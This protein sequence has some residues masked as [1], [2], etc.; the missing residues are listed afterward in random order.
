LT[1][2]PSLAYYRGQI[3]P[4]SPVS[5]HNAANIRNPKEGTTLKRLATVTIVVLACAILIA[6][7]SP[8]P[9]PKPGPEV[10]KL[11]YFAGNWKVEGETKPGPMGPG[12]KFTGTEHNEWMPGGFFLLSHGSETGSMGNGTSMAVYGYDLNEK[13]YTFHEFSSSGE[14]VHAKATVSGDTWTWTNEDKMEG[15][16]VRGRYTVKVASATAYS[17]KLELQIEGGEW[18]TAFEAKATKTK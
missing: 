3:D 2:S 7:Q 16:T 9:A 15:K 17:S 14:A 10:K 5:R 12:G 1:P 6:A 11:D 8:T 4:A 13:V 18:F